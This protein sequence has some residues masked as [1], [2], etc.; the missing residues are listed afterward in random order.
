MCSCAEEAA[1]AA[2]ASAGHVRGL[3]HISL[4]VY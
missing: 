1:P 2:P 4:Y 3:V